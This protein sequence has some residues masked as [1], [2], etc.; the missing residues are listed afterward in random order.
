MQVIWQRAATVQ[1]VGQHERTGRRLPR[2]HRQMLRHELCH[3]SM[4]HTGLGQPLRG[5][6]QHQLAFM[7]PNAPLPHEPVGTRQRHHGCAMACLTGAQVQAQSA[8]RQLRLPFQHQHDLDP[9][10][11]QIG[12]AHGAQIAHCRA[13][14][15]HALLH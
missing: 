8:I 14:Q 10:I 12:R 11:Q 15:H 7:P 13:V 3:P 2:C 4:Q 9:R 5:E 6:C 1:L